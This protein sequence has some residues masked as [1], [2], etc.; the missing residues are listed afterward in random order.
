MAFEIVHCSE[1][2][3]DTN[4]WY[5]QHMERNTTEPSSRRSLNVLAVSNSLTLH[6]REN[7]EEV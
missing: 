1:D 7:L 6:K 3:K 5:D 4:N 2:M